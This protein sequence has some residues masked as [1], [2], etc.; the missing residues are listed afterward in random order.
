MAEYIKG[1]DEL[2]LV[3]SEKGIAKKL[4]SEILGELLGFE[5]IKQSNNSLLI[6]DIT[7]TEKREI[8]DFVNRIFLILDSMAE[9]LVLSIEKKEDLSPIIEIDNSVNKFCNYCLRILN[10]YGYEDR[11]KTSQEG[12]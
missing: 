4:Q 1:V 5:I 8:N 6:K 2:E 11:T 7:G 10:K 12:H 3:F 9:E